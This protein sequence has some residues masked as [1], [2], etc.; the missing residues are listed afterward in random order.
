ME[1]QAPEVAE[2][3]FR[4]ATEIAPAQA[5]ARQQFGLN[6]LVLGRH[7]EAVL[8]LGEAVRLN[9][10][11]ADSLA[12]LAYGEFQLSRFAE[13]AQHARAALALDPGHPMAHQV[14]EAVRRIRGDT[15]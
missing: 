14:D 9:P 3:F 1:I 13:A 8:E 15:T 7:A 11:D 2:P 10:R 5:G 6:L 12:H 4:R